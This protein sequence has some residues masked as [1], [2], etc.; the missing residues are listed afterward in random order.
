MLNGPFGWLEGDRLKDRKKE[1]E[2]KQR[3]G[4]GERSILKK[5]T[6]DK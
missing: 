6:M 4:P 5:G 3:W 2:S 1:S